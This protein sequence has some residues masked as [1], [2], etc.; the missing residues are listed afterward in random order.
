MTTNLSSNTRGE[1]TT[2][3][4]K[5]ISNRQLPNFSS[6]TWRK[7]LP[8]K[9]SCPLGMLPVNKNEVKIN[10]CCKALTMRNEAGLISFINYTAVSGILTGMSSTSND[11]SGALAWL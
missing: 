8:P 1:H 3:N 11:E 7:T 9:I 6:H 2:S 10:Y 4:V 5:V